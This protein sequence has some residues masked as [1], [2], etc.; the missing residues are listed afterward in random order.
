MTRSPVRQ[1]SSREGKLLWATGSTVAPRVVTSGPV[2]APWSRARWSPTRSILASLDRSLQDHGPI[3]YFFM[4]SMSESTLAAPSAG[5]DRPKS[6]SVPTRVNSL[7]KP[8]AWDGVTWGGGTS[9]GAIDC[10]N[11]SAILACGSSSGAI[12]FCTAGIAGTPRSLVRILVAAGSVSRKSIS[13]AP[14]SVYFERDD[15]DQYMDALLTIFG[16]SPVA[17]A[18]SR[19]SVICVPLAVPK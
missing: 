5:L 2:S 12:S 11:S 4:V 13:L 9:S 14:A 3:D 16:D 6:T 15:T 10:E 17:C 8:E 1:R 18:G 19:S 7:L